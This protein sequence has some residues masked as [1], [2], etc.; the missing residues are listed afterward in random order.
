L[1]SRIY[2]HLIKPLSIGRTNKGD[3]KAARNTF[4]SGP[5]NATQKVWL[6]GRDHLEGMNL[7]FAWGFYNG[8][9]QWHGRQDLHVHP[10]PECHL[11]VGLDPANIN[12]LGAEIGCQLGEEN[13]PYTFAEPTVV[14][15]PAGLPHGPTVTRDIFSPKGFA[16]YMVAL[17]AEPE[18]TW[19]KKNTTNVS[20]I[21]RYAHFVKPLR[22]FQLTEGGKIKA[23]RFKPEQLAQRIEENK[24]N[25]MMLG[26][27]NADFLT[28]LFGSDLGGLGVNMDWGFFSK[29]GLWHRGVGAHLHSVDE[30]LV[31]VG[32]DS[33]NFDYLG[34][35]IEIDLG[36][37]HERYVIDKPSVVVLPAGVAHGPIVTRWVDRPYAF[38]SINLA[39]Q[40]V[41]KFID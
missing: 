25:K 40:L 13:E 17:G 23:S 34:A 37:E 7:N 39:G 32:T 4:N 18:T 36:Q 24:S 5:G 9:G 31:Y 20:S 38:F 21:A 8:L 1:A 28:W 14:I 2:G 22:P 26:P 3:P 11:F 12:Y 30:V 29:P 15:V 33:S 27:G 41:M 16:S 35:E 10:Y 6:N 19:L